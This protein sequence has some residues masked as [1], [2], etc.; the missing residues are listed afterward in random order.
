[1]EFTLGN[2]INPKRWMH[3]ERLD[4]VNFGETLCYVE[5][6]NCG[7]GA[8][9]KTGVNWKGYH[10]INRMAVVKFTVQSLLLRKENQLPLT[11]IPFSTAIRYRRTYY[12]INEIGKI[13]YKRSL[14]K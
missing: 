13:S 14:N 12:L 3:F 6:N 9:L 5:Y 1:M 7:P 2:F 8:N 4:K 10:K 11:S